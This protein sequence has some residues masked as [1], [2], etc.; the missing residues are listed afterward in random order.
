MAW[1]LT[2]VQLPSIPRLT[3]QTLSTWF[4][5]AL[6]ATYVTVM[7]I[8]LVQSY[9]LLAAPALHA[10]Y[11]KPILWVERLLRTLISVRLVA[12]SP[13][14][15]AW[16]AQAPFMRTA[17]L[18]LLNSGFTIAYW[19]VLCLPLDFSSQVMLTSAFVISILPA[20]LRDVHTALAAT[21]IAAAPCVQL[22]ELLLS[23]VGKGLALIG[24]A[25]YQGTWAAAPQPHA[26]PHSATSSNLMGIISSAE[27]TLCGS[28][29]SD[30]I[31]VGGGV[32][33]VCPAGSQSTS[34]LHH[35]LSGDEGA[36]AVALGVFAC[37]Y[38]LFLCAA[39]PLWLAYHTERVQKQ[40]WLMAH[41]S[42]A[43]SNPPRE[44][45]IGAWPTVR[46]ASGQLVKL[47]L[48]SFTAAEVIVATWRW[49][50]LP[51]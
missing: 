4:S 46:E 8:K 21:P 49:L 24:T 6:L 51:L 19:N 50:G 26:Q 44:K 41:P 20:S 3:S 42:V 17:R 47:L 35:S 13:Q 2:P 38:S 36:V 48:L 14:Y 7:A 16:L 31:T 45:P 30:N 27:A 39:L 43:W 32:C 37:C 1:P 18:L 9:L 34:G 25:A 23:A 28:A 11:R 22:H 40:R 15:Q 5:P 29:A 33:G 10:R 12:H